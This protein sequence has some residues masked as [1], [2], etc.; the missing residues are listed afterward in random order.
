[1]IVPFGRS[2]GIGVG[3]G[4]CAPGAGMTIVW[5]GLIGQEPLV[6]LLIAN[7]TSRS[8]LNAAAIS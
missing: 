6:K 7:N 2:L 8:T 3:V 1:M 5:P 4:S